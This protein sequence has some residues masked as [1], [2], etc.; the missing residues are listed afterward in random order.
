MKIECSCG[1]KLEIDES[2]FPGGS[3]LPTSAIESMV[4]AFQAAHIGCRP[5]Q[6]QEAKFTVEDVKKR[7]RSVRKQWAGLLEASSI[8]DCASLS[9]AREDN[10]ADLNGYIAALEWVISCMEKD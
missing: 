6:D 2:G 9:R 10:A 3:T 8:Q 5:A 1:A 7:L 4:A